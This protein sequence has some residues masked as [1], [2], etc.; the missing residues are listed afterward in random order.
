[1]IA[2]ALGA[3]VKRYVMD[4]L[5]RGVPGPSA[6][7]VGLT[8][9]EP[10]SDMSLAQLTEL[11]P[12]GAE[13]YGR[14]A[15]PAGSWN[16]DGLRVSYDDVW[17]VNSGERAWPPVAGVFVATSQGGEGV[18]VSAASLGGKRVLFPGDRWN[19][20]VIFEI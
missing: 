11:E 7:W 19:Q 20:P 18:V 2:T 9:V 12:A 10:A 15:V 3:G 5:F 17:F 8:T 1:M 16:G 13:G 14:V 4:F 6:L